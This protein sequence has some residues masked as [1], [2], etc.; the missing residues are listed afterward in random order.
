VS[1]G[2]NR[3]IHKGRC[4]NLQKKKYLEKTQLQVSFFFEMRSQVAQAGL[5]LKFLLLPMPP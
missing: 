1:K 5:K 2:K 4:A 3:P